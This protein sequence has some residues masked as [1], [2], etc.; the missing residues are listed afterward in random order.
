MTQMILSETVIGNLRE[1][2]QK[3]A[4]VLDMTR[5][6]ARHNHTCEDVVDWLTN[7][8][9]QDCE[10]KKT[11][12]IPGNA[13]IT[14]VYRDPLSREVVGYA[15]IDVYPT[16]TKETASLAMKKLHEEI[17]MCHYLHNVPP[18]WAA[19]VFLT[20]DDMTDFFEHVTEHGT[21]VR[22]VHDLNGTD[23]ELISALDDLY[24]SGDVDVEASM[25]RRGS[26]PVAILRKS[27]YFDDIEE[28]V[29]RPPTPIR[30][31]TPSSH[32]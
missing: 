20:S 32:I 12:L 22:A 27:K 13:D 8:S 19:V 15:L 29:V 28:S 18:T 17:D 31:S 23:H 7:I 24:S 6:F 16:E 30:K 10:P 4:E 3:T 9:S 1:M 14:A 2:V 21:R 11:G 5:P 26:D 25:L